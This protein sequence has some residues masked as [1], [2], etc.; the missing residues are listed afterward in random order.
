MSTT[1]PPCILSV[2]DNPDTRFLLELES[3]SF[4]L[5]LLD[6]HLGSGTE[7]TELLHTIRSRE[8]IEEVPA[9]ALTAYIL[10]SDSQELLDEGFDAYVSKPFT[11][12]ELTEAID[13]TLSGGVESVA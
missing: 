9:I 1:D 2:E 8:D 3:T 6:I 10:P 7:G 12:A 13:Q 4:D 5:L 11:S